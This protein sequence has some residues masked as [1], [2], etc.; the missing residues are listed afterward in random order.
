MKS[1]RLDKLRG[2]SRLPP[3]IHAVLPAVAGLPASRRARSD[4]LRTVRKILAAFLVAGNR[5]DLLIIPENSRVRTYRMTA[6][7][8]AALARTL[9]APAFS[10]VQNCW[11]D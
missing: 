5:K 11:A 10:L 7:A 4:E 8:Q 1:I 2:Q 9:E 3:E 6:L